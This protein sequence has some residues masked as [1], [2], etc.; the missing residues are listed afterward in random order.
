MNPPPGFTSTHG[1]SIVTKTYWKR[2]KP[3]SPT[4]KPELST[5]ADQTTLSSLW[6]TLCLIGEF[7]V[8]LLSQKESVIRKLT[9]YSDNSYHI[10]AI[11]LIDL[12]IYARR[13]GGILVER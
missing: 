2:A 9:L 8:E 5:H 7:H 4:S 1:D 13:G 3:L 11:S 10:S 6:H 12:P